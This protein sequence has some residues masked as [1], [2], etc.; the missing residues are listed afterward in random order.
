M[1][2]DYSRNVCDFIVGATSCMK[3]LPATG[4]TEASYWNICICFSQMGDPISVAL[5]HSGRNPAEECWQLERFLT[6]IKTE[7]I[8]I[9]STP[10]C[11]WRLWWHF[12]DH[13]IIV[14]FHKWKDFH[15]VEASYCKGLQYKKKHNMSPSCFWGVTHVSRETLHFNLSRNGAVYA[16]F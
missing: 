5:M 1:G 10:L 7:D 4:A 11:L 3:Q 6:L 9:F 2:V 16:M 14:E 12:L 13:W 8:P 15:P